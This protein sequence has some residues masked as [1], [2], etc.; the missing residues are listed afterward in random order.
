MALKQGHKTSE[1]VT[2]DTQVDKTATAL[3]TSAKYQ[4][5]HGLFIS[6]QKI[7]F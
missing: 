5:G 1:M 3:K 2:D 6:I 4:Q 7:G